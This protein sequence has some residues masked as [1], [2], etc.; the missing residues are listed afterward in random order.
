MIIYF[1]VKDKLTNASTCIFLVPR[2]SIVT[3]VNT[4]TIPSTIH[5]AQNILQHHF[6]FLRPFYTLS[7]SQIISKTNNISIP[8]FILLLEYPVSNYPYIPHQHHFPMQYSLHS[9]HL[10]YVHIL[11]LHIYLLFLQIPEQTNIPT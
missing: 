10:T 9:Y 4:L 7:S 1:N 6:L 5:N 8:L 2:K 11:Q 3:Y